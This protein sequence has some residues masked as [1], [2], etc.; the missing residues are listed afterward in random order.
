MKSE[1]TTVGYILMVISLVFN[2]FLYAYEQKLLIQYKVQPLEMVGWEG[3]YGTIL[4][5][6]LVTVLA[7]MPCP[8]SAA[9]CVYS[10]SSN[11]AHI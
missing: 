10:S 3:I 11:N 4:S 2:G 9:K 5:L 7:F 1:G 6:I 8:Y